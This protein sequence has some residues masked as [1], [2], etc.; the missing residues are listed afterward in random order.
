[1]DRHFRRS[2]CRRH[3]KT[4]GSTLSLP[5]LAVHAVALLSL[6][7]S[8]GCGP[9]LSGIEGVPCHSD[10]D[11]NAGLSCL[12][13]HVLSDGGG[14]DGGCA[15]VGNECLR[16]CRDSAD[17]TEGPGLTCVTFCGGT[18]ACE[19][20]SDVRSPEGGSS[21]AAAGGEAAAD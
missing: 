19:A 2:P 5:A 18:G 20:T 15:S 12:P 6:L 4:L 1:M 16:P 7:P 14:T 10:G 3:D 9:T 8:G 11:C 17:C 13:Y 21:E